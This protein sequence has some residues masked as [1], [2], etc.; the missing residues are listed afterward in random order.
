MIQKRSAVRVRRSSVRGRRRSGR[1]TWHLYVAISPFFVL[2]A[3]FGLIP[4]V[5]A[6]WLSLHRWDGLSEPV[7]VGFDQFVRLVRDGAF[8]QALVTTILIFVMAQ[9]PMLIGALGAAAVL[10]RLRGRSA[11]F[12]QTSFFLPQVTSLVMVSIVFQSLFSGSYG[13]VNKG[14]AAIG[15]P[16]VD[17]L[18]DWWGIKWVI[19]LMVIWRGFG[20]FMLIFLAGLASVPSTVYDAARVDGAGPFR[21]FGSITLPLLRPTLVFAVVISTIG[22]LQLFTEPQVLF[23]GLGGPDDAGRTLMLLQY[24][25]LGSTLGSAAL[26]DLGYGTAISIVTFVLLLAV[27]IAQG[28]RLRRSLTIS[29]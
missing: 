10:S 18:T 20:Y 27:S 9:V 16:V 19:A 21:T 11:A 4:L 23:N 28:R 29:E 3:S 13:I 25:Y 12:Y 14:L 26:P 22:G 7:F 2:F 24:Q 17:W 1:P 15:L 6:G 5:Y 8:L